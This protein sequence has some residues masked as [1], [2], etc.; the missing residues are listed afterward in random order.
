LAYIRVIAAREEV[1][2]RSPVELKGAD[3]GRACVR[4]LKQR[5]AEDLKKP[6]RVA[7]PGYIGDT[8]EHCRC[9]RSY[10]VDHQSLIPFVPTGVIDR[11]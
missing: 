8:F 6:F 11:K 3:R 10:T 7:L 2:W 4:Q 5:A 9:L 1:A